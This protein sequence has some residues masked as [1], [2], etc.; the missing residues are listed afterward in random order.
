MMSSLAIHYFR[1]RDPDKRFKPRITRERYASHDCGFSR[2]EIILHQHVLGSSYKTKV[3]LNWSKFDNIFQKLFE[4]QL[5]IDLTLYSVE[6]AKKLTK[7][8]SESTVSLKSNI[9]NLLS[10]ANRPLRFSRE[11]KVAKYQYG[12]KNYRDFRSKLD[13]INSIPITGF[14]FYASFD[15]KKGI[16]TH[17]IRTFTSDNDEEMLYYYDE[18]MKF[19]NKFLLANFWKLV[20]TYKKKVDI[21]YVENKE[22][23]FKKGDL[24]FLVNGNSLLNISNKI[25]KE[26]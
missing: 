11:H 15:I 21:S 18:L 3:K 20:H 25:V 6:N 16:K 26:R 5:K 2:Q 9:V 4:N 1:Q 7:V 8:K 10:N 22:E 14:T 23:T 19:F 24:V 17:L 12:L 13:G